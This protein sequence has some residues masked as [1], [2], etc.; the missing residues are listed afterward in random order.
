MIL[1]KIITIII[2]AGMLASSIFAGS[3]SG[4]VNFQ[5]NAPK[6]KTLKM[7]ADPVCG[8]AHKTPPYRQSFIMNDEGYLKNVMVYLQDVKYDGKTL[9]TQAVLDQTGCMYVPHVQG[10]M[11]GQDLL[12]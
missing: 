2:L 5:G 8:A 3:L 7:D 9:E 6:K 4:R 11:A 1:R 12:I 10:M